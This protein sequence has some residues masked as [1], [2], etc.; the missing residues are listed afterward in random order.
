MVATVLSY[1]ADLHYKEDSCKLA[2][3]RSVFG[4]GRS[5]GWSLFCYLS[6]LLWLSRLSSFF[7]SHL[8]IFALQ[9]LFHAGKR[10]HI[11]HVIALV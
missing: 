8:K 2:Q 1:D 6:W 11:G 5:S 10:C 3:Q 4:F 9:T 7:K